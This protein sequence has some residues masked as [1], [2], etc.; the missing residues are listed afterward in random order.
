MPD[1]SVKTIKDQIFF[2]YA[3]QIA[4]SSFWYKDGL[5]AKKESIL[6]YKTKI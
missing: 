5:E 3:K 2:Q 1:S 4:R 6:I